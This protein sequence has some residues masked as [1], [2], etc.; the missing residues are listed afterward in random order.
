MI[1]DTVLHGRVLP[2]AQCCAN[3][4]IQ[5][6]AE[7]IGHLVCADMQACRLQQW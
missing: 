1:L 6:I 7:E 4:Q 3:T 5:A 2:S